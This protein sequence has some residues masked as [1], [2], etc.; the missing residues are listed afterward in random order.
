MRQSIKVLIENKQFS[1]A[2]KLLNEF[3]MIASVHKY[4]S[5]QKDLIE[6]K[7]TATLIK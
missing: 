1:M 7:R 4:K 3:A 5:L 6:A 2:E